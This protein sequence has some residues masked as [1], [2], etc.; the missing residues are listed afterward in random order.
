VVLSTGAHQA[1]RWLSGMPRLAIVGH[2]AKHESRYDNLRSLFGRHAR[3]HFHV[4]STDPLLYEMVLNSA[5]MG[6]EQAA[7]T[8]VGLLRAKFPK[9]ELP[10]LAA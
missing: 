7:E 5:R 1:A 10:M 6:Y 8:I 3:M 4:K 2:S 9:V